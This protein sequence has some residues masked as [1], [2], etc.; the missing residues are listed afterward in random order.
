ML[1]NRFKC[2]CLNAKNFNYKRAYL[3]ISDSSPRSPSQF[4][5]M[6]LLPKNIFYI[7]NMSM[8]NYPEE[9][10]ANNY[11]QQLGHV[12]DRDRGIVRDSSKYL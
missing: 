5:K 2:Y 8:N 10:M 6:D 12:S 1:G 4:T 7:E 9:K 3:T 11:H